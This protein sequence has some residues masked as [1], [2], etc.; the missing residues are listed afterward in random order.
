MSVTITRGG[1]EVQID[2]LAHGRRRVSVRVADHA[3]FGPATLCETAYPV[4]LIEHVLNVKG[5]VYLCDEIMRDEDPG[6]VQACLEADLLSYVDAGCFEGKTILDYGCGCGASTMVLARMFPSASITGVDIGEKLVALARARADFYGL[7][8]VTIAVS[9]DGRRLPDGVGPFDFV[10]LSAVY[11]HL[12]PDERPAV[13]AS[14]WRALRPGG[15]L[16]LDQTPHRYSPVESHTTGLPLVN[17]LPDSVALFLARR[18]SRRV[19]T[20][21]TREQLLRD[22][23]R[24]GTAREILNHVR[25][26]SDDE[27][28]LLEPRLGGCRDRIDL[29]YAL[30]GGARFRQ[31]KGAL[32]AAAK[33]IKYTTGVVLVPNLSLAVK[34]PD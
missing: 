20:G 34:K 4:E 16:F 22:G 19:P 13:L 7:S 18:F 15:I 28:V 1:G 25:S 5:P 8:R 14:L 10:V 23:I 32:K 26:A 29:W 24:G 31:L 27:P 17:Y 21:A 2:E 3:N 9:P 12:L 11:E 30:S 33:V 6:S